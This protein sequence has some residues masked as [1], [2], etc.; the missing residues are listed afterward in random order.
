MSPLEQYNSIVYFRQQYPLVK[1]ERHHIIPKSCGGPLKAKWNLVKLTPEEHIECH[2]LLCE[3][4]PTGKEHQAMVYAWHLLTT[5]HGVKLSKEEAAKL[6]SQMKAVM[7]TKTLTEQHKKAILAAHVGVPRSEET[8]RKISEARKGQPSA[9]KGKHHTESTRKHLSEC[10]KKY[11]ENHPN[12]MQGYHHTEEAK[13]KLR[14]AAL[15][16]VARKKGNNS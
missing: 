10:R 1:G 16:R 4:Y 12:P 2:R 6:R 9:F 13:L 14:E 15:R 8:K 11:Y 3:I 7:Q 5:S